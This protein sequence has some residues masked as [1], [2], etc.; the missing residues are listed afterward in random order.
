LVQ[1]LPD[2]LRWRQP[3]LLPVLL[4]QQVRL[5]VRAEL[6]VLVAAVA[7]AVAVAQ[8]ARMVVP[9]ATLDKQSS[10]RAPSAITTRIFALATDP[11]LGGRLLITL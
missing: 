7:V 8:P 3:E 10:R 2:S 1:W 9:V 4:V 11:P 6:V 5:V